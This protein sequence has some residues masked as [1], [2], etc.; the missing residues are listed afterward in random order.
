MLKRLILAVAIAG[1]I[2]FGHTVVTASPVASGYTPLCQVW[3]DTYVYMYGD[4]PQLI[5]TREDYEYWSWWMSLVDCTSNLAQVR[6][7][8]WGNEVCQAYQAE[9]AVLDWWYNFHDRD[10]HLYLGHLVQQYDC[11]DLP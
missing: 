6:V 1:V 4:P 7:K 8:Q 11:D 2:A 10:W 5:G 9:F 3:N